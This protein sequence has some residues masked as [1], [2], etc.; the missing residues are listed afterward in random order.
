MTDEA[1]LPDTHELADEGVAL[2]SGARADGDPPLDLDE[3]ADEH[4]VSE[5]ATVE[6]DEIKD[7]NIAPQLNVRSNAL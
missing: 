4:A 5:R 2:H 3:R 1:I 6:V 7:P